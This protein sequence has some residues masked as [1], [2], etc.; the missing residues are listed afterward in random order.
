MED[1]LRKY[2]AVPTRMG[3][4]YTELN[5][6]SYP[7]CS[8]IMGISAYNLIREKGQKGRQEEQRLRELA[9]LY[10]KDSEHAF[11][12]ICFQWKRGQDFTEEEKEILRCR[13]L[14]WKLWD[15]KGRIV[16]E[17]KGPTYRDLKRENRILREQLKQA[18]L[19]PE[20]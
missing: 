17:K 11:D 6:M 19:T 8:L 13:N 9:R 1:I 18:G 16:N 14:T 7:T 2:P 10:G 5:T 20:V 15:R 4:G 12:V 3:D